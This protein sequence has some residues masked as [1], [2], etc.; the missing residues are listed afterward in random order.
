MFKG[1]PQGI[2]GKTQGGGEGSGIWDQRTSM[3]T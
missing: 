1:I 2:K 3:L